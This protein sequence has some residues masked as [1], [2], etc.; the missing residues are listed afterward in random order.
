MHGD[1]A[2]NG[3]VASC[4]TDALPTTAARLLLAPVAW[5]YSGATQVAAAATALFR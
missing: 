1:I 4:L 3:V 5:A 2:V